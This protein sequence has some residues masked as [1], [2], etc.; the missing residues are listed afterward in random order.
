[1]RYSP[2]NPCI[3]RG[4]PGMCTPRYRDVL[5]RQAV[6]PTSWAGRTGPMPI[7]ARAR[8]DL[9]GERLGL[10]AALPHLDHPHQSVIADR[11]DVNRA[12]KRSRIA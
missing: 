9:L 8:D 10:I 6:A 1:M 2:G 7:S 5:I 3:S 12:A 4:F 11:G